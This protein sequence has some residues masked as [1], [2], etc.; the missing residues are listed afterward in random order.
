MSRGISS[1]SISGVFS[2]CSPN[3]EGNP[4][5][6]K[7]TEHGLIMQT[8][9]GE[10]MDCFKEETK[11]TILNV[12]ACLPQSNQSADIESISDMIIPFARRKA[13][14]LKTIQ[15][16]TSY[17]ELKEK[18]EFVIEVKETESF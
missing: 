12:L 11:D 10:V 17:E 8:T 16:L 14:D 7:N 6:G 18:D 3:F 15:E 2:D 1:G 4:Y 13:A 5:T 9:F